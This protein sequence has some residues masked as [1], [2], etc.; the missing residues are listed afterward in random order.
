MRH[1]SHILL[2]LFVT[3]YAVNITDTKNFLIPN[4]FESDLSFQSK[5]KKNNKRKP[6]LRVDSTLL[7]FNVTAAPGRINIGDRDYGKDVY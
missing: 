3:C 4:D 1:F 6:V 2:L 7:G 5:V